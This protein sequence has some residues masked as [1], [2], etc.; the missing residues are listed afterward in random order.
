[1]SKLILVGGGGFAKEVHEIADLNNHEVIGY[2]AEAE[3]VVN[4]PYLGHVDNLSEVAADAD[5]VVIAFGAVDRKSVER[6]AALIKSIEE[7][8]LEFLAL[9]SPHATVA[10]GAMIG[11]G[12]IVAHGVV[13]SVDA[14]IGNHAILNT[15]AII[16]HDAIIGDRVII[17]PGAFIGGTTTIGE[18]SLVGPNANILQARTVGNNV[19]IGVGAGVVRDV[20]SGM[21]VFPTR[22]TARH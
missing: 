13:I 16:G 19:I 3:G 21:T 5:Y 15:S 2:V 9:V 18:D 20:E 8:G 1:M 17:A 11:K 4:L 6:R 14:K 22:S 10:R 12:A 7:S